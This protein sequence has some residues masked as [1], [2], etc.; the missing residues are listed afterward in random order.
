[1]YAQERGLRDEGLIALAL[2]GAIEGSAR[3]I[4]R[5]DSFN[6]PDSAP[7][8]EVAKANT[9]TAIGVLSQRELRDADTHHL[10]PLALE[11][12]TKGQLRA[13]IDA[14]YGLLEAGTPTV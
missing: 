8:N 4:A 2:K 10:L 14:T 12:K 3:F 6:G 9:I 11:A 5:Q 7:V 1:M 13:A